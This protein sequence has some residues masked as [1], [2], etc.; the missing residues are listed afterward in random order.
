VPVTA[1]FRWS[2]VVPLLVLAGLFGMHGLG[3]HD[4]AHPGMTMPSVA[5]AT[6][7]LDAATA[8]P[9]PAD[10]LSGMAMGLCVAILLG[11]LMAWLV[12]AV[13]GRRTPWALPR[14]ALAPVPVP[15][16]RAPDPPTPSFLSVYRC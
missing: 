12:L 11:G 15:R 2:L 9:V 3:D 10:D 7:V 5:E 4:A 1:R 13:A 8:S 6:A 14:V 16:S